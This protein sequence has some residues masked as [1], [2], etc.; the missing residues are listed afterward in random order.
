MTSILPSDGPATDPPS[1]GAASDTATLTGAEKAALVLVSLGEETGGALMRSLEEADLRRIGTALS[2]LRRVPAALVEASLAEFADAVAG[3]GSSIGGRDVARRLLAG[4]LPDAEVEAILDGRGTP[5]RER[6]AWRR[7]AAMEPA[8]IAACLAPEPPQAVATILAHLPPRTAAAVYP[9]LATDRRA[10]VIE[11]MTALG[12]YPDHLIDD[13]EAAVHD[14]LVARASDDAEGS[15]RDVVAEMLS[16]LGPDERAEAIE[17]LDRTDPAVG[18]DVRDRMFTF[19]DMIRIDPRGLA[20]LMREVEGT[21][22]PTALA[23]THETMREH[24]LSALP[25]RSRGMLEREIEQR[26]HPEAEEAQA[27][28]L[29]LVDA[30]KGLLRADDIALTKRR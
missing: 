20:R 23:G 11:R 8:R 24:F 16:A 15:A 10:D 26:G 1:G 12:T 14:D 21:L 7:L 6:A 13:I 28:Q 29:K 30:A 25:A 4:I 17:A 5:R 18:A 27:A 19:D 3:G 2:T 9:L 22:V